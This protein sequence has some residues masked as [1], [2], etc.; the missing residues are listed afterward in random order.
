MSREPSTTGAAHVLDPETLGDHIDRLYRAAWA[1]SRSR[2]DAE[3][4][5]Q[6][7]FARV[8]ARPRLVRGG[9]DIGY[10]L[11]AL[12]NLVIDQRLKAARQPR[13]AT[14]ADHHEL[15]DA[16]TSTHPARALEAAEL[17]AA[18]ARLPQDFRNVLVAVDLA[19]LEY[20]EAARALGIPVGTVM[21]RLY[22]ARQ[23]IAL[24]FDDGRLDAV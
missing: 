15:A 10:L 17:H 5:V 14:L 8:L 23:R 18:L 6:E 1:H 11:V 20:K 12:R 21:S 9:D 13:T 7:T 16:R 19:G 24:Q 22:R 2:T 4:L 3:D